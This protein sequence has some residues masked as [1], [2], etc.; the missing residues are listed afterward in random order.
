M[1]T[2]GEVKGAHKEASSEYIFSSTVVKPVFSPVV[3]NLWVRYK[4]DHIPV[5]VFFFNISHCGTEIN[6]AS[7]SNAYYPSRCAAGGLFL[8]LENE[9]EE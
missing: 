8:L 5:F 7:H 9:W 3:C 2:L 6:F 4:M 1:K